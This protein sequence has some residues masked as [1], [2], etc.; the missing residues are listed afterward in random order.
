MLYSPIVPSIGIAIL[1]WST[2]TIVCVLT[3]HLHELH[4]NILLDQ[5]GEIE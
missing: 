2:T 1:F 5:M 4:Y 3:K